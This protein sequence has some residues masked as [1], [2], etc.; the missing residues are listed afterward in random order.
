MKAE[1]GFGNVAFNQ[2]SGDVV[3]VMIGESF[4]LVLSGADVTTGLRF[5]T[6][7]DPVLETGEGSNAMTVLAAK[8][9]ASE[10]QV[11]APD[12]RVVFYL[13]VLVYSSEAS[14]LSMPEPHVEDAP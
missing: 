14:S 1:L 8:V 13:T 7:N 3:Q 5:A 12:R 10:I 11:Q 9:G 6:T 4:R 2:V